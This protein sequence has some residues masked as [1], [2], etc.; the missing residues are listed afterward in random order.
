MPK[1]AILSTPEQRRFDSP[2]KFNVHGRLLY[3]SLNKAELDLVKAL[4]KPTNKVGFTLQLGYFKA[5][6]KFFGVE[7][8]H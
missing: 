3:F 5:Y 1:L 7:Q 6:G 8:F 4:H 2:T